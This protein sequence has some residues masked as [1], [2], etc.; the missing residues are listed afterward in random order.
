MVDGVEKW[1]DCGKMK[2]KKGGREGEMEIGEG[3]KDE[4]W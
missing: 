3:D 2:E 4:G 1:G